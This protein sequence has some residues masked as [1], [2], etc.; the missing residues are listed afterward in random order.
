MDKDEQIIENLKT[1]HRKLHEFST[2][3]DLIDFLAGIF[4]ENYKNSTYIITLTGGPGSGKS[5]LREELIRKL[6]EDGHKSDYVS[7]DDFGMYGRVERNQ[8]IAEG[9]TPLEVKDFQYLNKLIDKIKLGNSVKAP[10]YNEATGD[11]IVVGEE[12]FP[13]TIPANLHFF[14]VEGDFQPVINY[15]TSIYFHVPTPV[16]REN[17]VERDME[18]RNGGDPE[19][20]RESFN[21]RLDSQYYPYTLPAAKKADYLICV[22]SKE[23]PENHAYRT[24]YIYSVYKNK[25]S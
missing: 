20:I 8:K 24:H 19:K 7:T 2:D 21:F 6:E 13:H 10:V 23:S 18:K 17:R 22:E 16:R 25:E 9:A 14:I 1:T 12:N 11:A 4:E 15:N 3:K 5:T